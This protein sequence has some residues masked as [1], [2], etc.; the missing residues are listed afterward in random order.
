MAALSLGHATPLGRGARAP[1]ALVVTVVHNPEDSRIR[2]RQLAALIAAG[3]DVTY[4]APF[5]PSDSNFHQLAPRLQ[6]VA[7]CGASM[8]PG[9]PADAVSGHGGRPARSCGLW[10]AITMLFW[11]MIRSLFWRLRGL[12]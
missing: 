8:S 6:A 7:V 2:R 4:V 3:W 9:P 11:F 1:S 5:Q 10:A 12:T